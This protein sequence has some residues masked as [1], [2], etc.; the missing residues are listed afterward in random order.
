MNIEKYMLNG[1][2]PY[3]KHQDEGKCS[4]GGNGGFSHPELLSPIE[5]PV[6]HGI[7]VVKNRNASPV[8]EDPLGS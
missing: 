5:C 6:C 2:G 3:E 1:G 7:G 4:C 8:K